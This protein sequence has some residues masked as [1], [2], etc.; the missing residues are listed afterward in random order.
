M[1]SLERCVGGGGGGEFNRDG[2]DD[3][4]VRAPFQGVMDRGAV[5]VFLSNVQVNLHFTSF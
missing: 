1:T 2:L 5:H 4:L 3:L